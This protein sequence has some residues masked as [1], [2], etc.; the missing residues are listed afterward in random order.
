M[1]DE[2]AQPT[3]NPTAPIERK[4]LPVWARYVVAAL[5]ILTL[6]WL[7]SLAASRRVYAAER[8]ATQE[9]AA[10]VGALFA[11]TRMAGSAQI[12]AGRITK[13]VDALRASGAYERVTFVAAGGQ[14][15]ASTDKNLQGGTLQDLSKPPAKTEGRDQ[16][17]TFTVDVPVNYGAGPV[18]TLRLE[19]KLG[20]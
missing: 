4:P 10:A 19:A 15:V 7:Q 6:L 8:E 11:E 3:P 20:R 1:A 14:V 17:G 12:D 9:G 16:S 2:S 18:G 5:I 13:L